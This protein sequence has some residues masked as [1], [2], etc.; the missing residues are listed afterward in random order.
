[1]QGT[2]EIAMKISRWGFKQAKQVWLTFAQPAG[3]DKLRKSRPGVTYSWGQHNY[4]DGNQ[5]FQQRVKRGFG[6]SIGRVFIGF[7]QVARPEERANDGLDA[8]SIHDP[9][10]TPAYG[11]PA[12]WERVHTDYTREN[13]EH[14][15]L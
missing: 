9:L 12:Y 11:S 3:T 6:I 2:Q 10:E 4:V 15:G 8:Q 13:L 7:I 1:V 5:V 14:A